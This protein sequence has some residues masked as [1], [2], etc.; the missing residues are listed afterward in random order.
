[1]LREDVV[2][3]KD[4]ARMLGCSWR[5]V[6]RYA[7][8]GQVRVYGRRPLLVSVSEVGEAMNPR[9]RTAVEEIDIAVRLAPEARRAF[10]ELQ[11]ATVAACQAGTPPPCVTTPG[12]LWLADDAGDR[13]RAAE[14]CAGCPA[15]AACGNYADLANERFGTWAGVDRGAA[16]T[17]DSEEVA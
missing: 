13:R 14:L 10:A 11:R 12:D 2:T 6:Y 1:M 5:A 4:A 15:F 8:M 7:E 3:A 9:T 17:N 16:R